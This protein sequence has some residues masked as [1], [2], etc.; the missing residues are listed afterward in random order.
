MLRKFTNKN[1]DLW[2]GE[3]AV[4]SLNVYLFLKHWCMKYVRPLKSLGEWCT[5]MGKCPEGNGRVREAVIITL[6][7]D[8]C[9]GGR[10]C[11]MLLW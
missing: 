8:F 3:N 1:T 9:K 5:N 11:L 2:P 7:N 6:F 4:V 10:Y